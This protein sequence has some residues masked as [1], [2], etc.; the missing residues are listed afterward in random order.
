[1]TVRGATSARTR[2][3]LRVGDWAVLSDM[4]GTLLD[5]EETWR[6]VIVDVVASRDRAATPAIMA[7]IEGA[8]LEQ[9]SKLLVRALSLVEYPWELA[10]EI[11][12]RMIGQFQYGVLWRPGAA[13]LID[14]L[15][16]VGIPLALV[17]SSP[18]RWVTI[19]RQTVDLS[20]FDVV[21]TVDDVRSPKPD[22]APY[23]LAARQLGFETDHCI[24]LEDSRLG[25]RSA[26][27]AGCRV[28]LID[29]KGQVETPSEVSQVD[30]LA[31]V[32]AAVLR[33]RIFRLKAA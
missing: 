32:S 16:K 24:A 8:T 7:A 14:E 18:R 19:L 31:E 26:L 21:V 1:M 15:S 9:A 11:E 17:T 10:Q 27:R 28:T 13:E 25:M 29:G 22:P 30:S 20:A 23:L 6:R 33:D 4:D 12:R 5:T 2:A 3:R